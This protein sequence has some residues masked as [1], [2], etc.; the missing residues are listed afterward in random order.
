MYTL[1]E[2]IEA[3]PVEV[4]QRP[5]PPARPMVLASM[6]QDE[7]KI[8]ERARKYLAKLPSSIEGQDGSGSLMRA[9]GA[10][11]GFGLDGTV[12]LGL[13]CEFDSRSAPA[14]PAVELVRALENAWKS[15]KL[16]PG[17]L[18]DSTAP[19]Y[20]ATS[21]TPDAVPAE[22]PLDDETPA[23]VAPPTKPKAQTLLRIVPPDTSTDDDAVMQDGATPDDRRLITTTMLFDEYLARKTT[24]VPCALAGLAKLLH[25]GFETGK[26]TVVTAPAGAGKTGFLV[27]HAA[28]AVTHGDFFA[29][30]ALKDGDQWSDGLRLA[31]MAGVDRFELRDRVPEAIEAAR[32]AMARYADRLMVYDVSKPGASFVDMAEQA[33]RWVDGRGHLVLG[34]D[35]VHVF[36]VADQVKERAMPIYDRMSFRFEAIHDFVVANDVAGLTVGQSGRAAYSKKRDEENVDLL[37]SISGG[38]VAEN[39]VDVLVVLTKPNESGTRFLVVP[40]SRLG[41]QGSR[42]PVTYDEERSLWL[43]AEPVAEDTVP[44]ESKAKARQAAKDEKDRQATEGLELVFRQ[45]P[46]GL[47]ADEARALVSR[48]K[49]WVADKIGKLAPRYIRSVMVERVNTRKQTIRVPV[50]QWQ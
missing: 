48:S 10:L 50:W 36:A 28:H 27:Q 7:G 38:H 17:C 16:P 1:A 8:A 18:L 2:M 37:A 26:N 14:W 12:A 22:E 29:V 6:K 39:T 33:L 11:V 25:G 44:K 5:A 3:H 15:P 23:P 35:S 20:T 49:A 32:E 31:Q 21:D 45:N 9:A 24:V 13:L 47:T 4:K 30:L 41:G 42:V 34:T 46:A 19:A 40:K 43:D